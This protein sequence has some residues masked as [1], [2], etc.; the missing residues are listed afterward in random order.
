MLLVLK[1]RRCKCQN[2]IWLKN[3]SSRYFN[4]YRIRGPLDPNEAD[5]IAAREFHELYVPDLHDRLGDSTVQKLKLD[6][7]S[8]AGGRHAYLFSGT[9]GSGKST[10]LRRLANELRPANFALVVNAQDYLN[11]QLELSISELLIAMSLAVWEASWRPAWPIHSACQP[12]T[13]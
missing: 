5:P 7:L 11:P 6:V 12:R 1:N 2:S 10:E 3:S 8:A 9:I 13:F 4:A